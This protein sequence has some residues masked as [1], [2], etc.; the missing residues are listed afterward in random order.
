MR[1][2]FTQ[3]IGLLLLSLNLWAQNTDVP[4]VDEKL[5]YPTAMA[6]A[7]R[8]QEIIDQKKNKY[9]RRFIKLSSA[10]MQDEVVPIKLPKEVK[11]TGDYEKVIGVTLL[12]SSNSLRFAP[13]E[14]GRVALVLLDAKD[15][16]LIEYRVE[17]VEHILD[18]AL[19]ELQVLLADIDGIHMRIINNKIIIDG[20]VLL[21]NEIGRIHNVTVNYKDVVINLVT[22]SANSMKKIAEVIAKEI[23]NP[24]VEVRA[25]NNAIY[26]QGVVSSED[27]KNKAEAI[28]KLYLPG[29]TQDA[30]E[31]AQVV[32]KNKINN[33][34]VVN[35]LSVKEPSKPPPPQPKM[36]QLVVHFVEMAKDYEKGFLFQFMPGI[37]DQTQAS[38]TTGGGGQGTAT[39]IAGV[40]NNLLPKLHW[41]KKHSYARVLQS[42]SL[43]VQDQK[44]GSLKSTVRVPDGSV[45]AQGA[46]GQNMRDVGFQMQVTPVVM[47]ERGDLI[48]LT[49]QMSVS[50]PLEGSSGVTTNDVQTDIAVRSGQ[51]AAFAGMI[52]NVSGSGFNK[53]LP[54]PDRN[55]LITMHA[56]RNF[57]RDQGQFVMFITPVIKSS[58]SQ[59]TDKIKRKFKLSE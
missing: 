32:K 10:V 16:I 46:V 51:S 35:H 48:N 21:L 33:Q 36:I 49:M 54:G 23:N 3:T 19:R 1:S 7:I 9:K 57:S 17:V 43:I 38:F 44:T 34:G 28:A 42:S 30:A 37:S 45:A 4:Q 55:P 58:A 5:V 53:N 12:P 29:S 40:I 24:E 22:L 8:D 52:R 11:F 25:I 6:E 56:D 20:H 13:K 50:S 39:T 27:E 18:S 41:G 15:K 59:G 14:K 47:G 26:L 31:S 2:N